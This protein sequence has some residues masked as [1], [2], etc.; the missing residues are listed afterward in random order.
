M[1]DGDVD[2]PRC[3]AGLLLRLE[4]LVDL[5]RAGIAGPGADRTDLDA[6]IPLL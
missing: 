1:D 2:V 4:L 5:L 6:R 3:A